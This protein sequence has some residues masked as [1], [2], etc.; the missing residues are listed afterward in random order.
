M[1]DHPGAPVPGPWLPQ[2]VARRGRFP[3]GRERLPEDVPFP[4]TPLL[5]MAFQLLAF[6][7]LTYTP[8]S[9]ETR[10]DL[11]L[12]ATP[13]ALPRPTPADAETPTVRPPAE[14]IVRARAS[15]V[16]GLES[17]TLDGAPIAGPQALRER[18]LATPA[19]RARP[20]RLVA[21]ESLRYEVAARLVA[22]L[23]AAGV[24]SVRLAA[25][26]ARPDVSTVAPRP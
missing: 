13:A 6:F 5:D 4:V 14:S 25:A 9:R 20:A 24:P 19:L 7:L 15:A 23:Q 26:L 8:P 18:L 3:A 17:L 12:P 2:A 16:G 10:L 22:A 11:D 21:D 1:S